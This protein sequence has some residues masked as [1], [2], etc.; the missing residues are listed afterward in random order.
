MNVG[1]NS[2]SGATIKITTV[3]GFAVG[4]GF[5]PV[6]VRIENRVPEARVWQ[7]R[8]T[9]GIENAGTAL[10]SSYRFSVPALSTQETVVFVPTTGISSPHTY[11]PLRAQFEGPGV[12]PGLSLQI[13]LSPTHSGGG[14]ALNLAPIATTPVT[15]AALR[16]IWP[17]QPGPRA[18]SGPRRPGSS[19]MPLAIVD[20]SSWP[21]DWRT[22]SLFAFIVMTEREWDDLS[23]AR[24]SALRDWVAMGGRLVL[25]RDPDAGDV[26]PAQKAPLGLGLMVKLGSTLEQA[27]LAAFS[28]LG[29]YATANRDRPWGDVAPLLTT[30]DDARWTIDTSVRWPVLFLVAFGIVIGPVNFFV[31]APRGRRHRLFF[32]VP[33]LSLAATL[34]LGVSILLR[35]GFGGEGTRRA[36]VLLVP[37]ENKAVVMQQQ[38]ARTGMLG[39]RT[40]PVAEDTV[41]GYDR[42]ASGTRASPRTKRTFERSADAASGDW[43]TSSEKQT[44]Q[45]R[46]ITPTRARVEWVAGGAD[47]AAPVVQSSLTTVLTDFLYV[48][49][50][51]SE[52]TV[53]ELPPGKRVALV[54][55]AKTKRG[56]AARQQ[57]QQRRPGHFYASGGA[58]DLAP[59]ATLQSIK[60]VDDTVLYCGAVEKAVER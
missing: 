49:S 9:V 42:E 4:A 13:A 32:T 16:A 41:L 28:E 22:W 23:H 53:N 24:R 34:I 54:P 21:A 40:F 11:V 43:F 10:D 15:E 36:L 6:L 20:P 52:W 44:L 19:E 18:A 38:V 5:L 39:S 31:F 59:I 57:F 50:Q 2:N 48:D 33:L 7:A 29:I 60:W 26:A 25:A 1:M 3:T 17:H 14:S 8:M 46:R 45:L 56:L 12:Q 47:G 51:G 58:T 35:D 37:G 27:K 55:V 30:A